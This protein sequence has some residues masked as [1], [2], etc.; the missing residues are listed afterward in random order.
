MEPLILLSNISIKISN[1]LNKS[2]THLIIAQLSLALAP[3]ACYLQIHNYI[4]SW[5]CLGFLPTVVNL[6]VVDKFMIVIKSLDHLRLH[7]QMVL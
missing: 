3:G 5:A 1:E 6:V 7:L 4:G 2:A